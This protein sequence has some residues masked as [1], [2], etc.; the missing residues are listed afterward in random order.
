MSMAG[1]LDFVTVM[2]DALNR[3]D[4]SKGYVDV[5]HLIDRHPNYLAIYLLSK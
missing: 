4:W 3:E 5:L 2:N 1:V